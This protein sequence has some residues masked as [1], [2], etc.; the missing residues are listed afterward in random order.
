[1]KTIV[2]Q[3][4]LS[5]NPFE[6]YTAETEPHITEYAVRPP[7]LEAIAARAL[8]LSSFILFGDRGAGKSATRITVFNQIWNGKNVDG[9]RPLVV[10]LTDFTNVLPSLKRGTLADKDLVEAASFV[11]AEQVLIWLSAHEDGDR[12]RLLDALDTNQ[13]KL[14]HT[15]ITEFYLA[16]PEMERQF[17][18]QEAFKILGSALAA[19]SSSWLA[20]RWDA[21]SATIASI[22]TA[23]TSKESGEGVVQAT[24]GLAKALK[25]DQPHAG[26]A[27]LSRL[28]QF[29]QMFEFSGVVV[30]IDKVDETDLTTNSVENTTKLIF[31]LLAHIQL[32][33]VN[34]F[35]WHFFL[36]SRV[37]SFFDE[38]Q[39]NIRLDKIANSL[40]T[41]DRNDFRKMLDERLRYFSNGKATFRDLFVDDKTA[42]ETFDQVI[43]IAMGSPRELV[44]IMDVIIREHDAANFSQTDR[45]LSDSSVSRGLDKYVRDVTST[46]FSERSLG[47]IYRLRK[48]K[49]INREVQTAFRIN[50]QS[51]RNKIKG[52]EDAGLVRLIGTRAAEGDY[53]GKPANEYM[54]ADARI[55]RIMTRDLVKL[56]ELEDDS[57]DTE[58]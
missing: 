37:K 53:G 11:V 9:A 7:Y 30:L 43:E 3:L 15:I 36:W 20:N 46:A 21:L 35:A 1:M 55:A 48:T 24:E 12:K 10:N 33:E 51:A 28:V 31:P 27:V 52:W 47:Q 45:L 4:G 8:G 44:K 41:W 18:T 17:R 26:R 34:G 2:T 16:R 56:E 49:F 22:M 14:A 25:G 57:S 32:L 54:I 42:E 39:Y 38:G 50:D 13:R 6:H 58:Q 40:I 5:G 19:R 23:I 29:V